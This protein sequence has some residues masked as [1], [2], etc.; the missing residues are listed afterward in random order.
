MTLTAGS[1]WPA[2]LLVIV[3]HMG[4]FAAL[5][6]HRPERSA[7]PFRPAS[8][9]RLWLLP[10]PTIPAGRSAVPARLP[11]QP[12]APSKQTPRD[13]GLQADKPARST[14]PSPAPRPGDP[15][16]AAD[17]GTEVGAEVGSVVGAGRS[18][19]PIAPP[20][21]GSAPLNL[22]LPRDYARS[23]QYAT[24]PALN[25]VRGNTPRSLLEGRIANE[26][27]GDGRW[28]EEQMDNDRRRLRR[29]NLC[30]DI[31][32]SRQVL[33]NPFNQSVAPLMA[34]FGQPYRCERR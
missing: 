7:E 8:A 32:R 4:L 29:G 27:G 15:A 12:P 5:W 34:E 28:V 30:V 9:I 11:A 19:L 33:T 25:D 14:T 22:S 23:G 26:L 10:L 21:P 3:L 2:R 20:T 1:R 16:V 24:N 6:L 31:A 18:V 13:A 17:V